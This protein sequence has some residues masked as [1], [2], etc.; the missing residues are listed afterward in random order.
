MVDRIITSWGAY[1]L[2]GLHPLNYASSEFTCIKLMCRTHRRRSWIL[3]RVHAKPSS[4]TRTSVWHTW[5]CMGPCCSTWSFNTCN[6]SFALLW[7]TV[8]QVTFWN[9][10]LVPPWWCHRKGLFWDGVCILRCSVL[11]LPENSVVPLNS[12][13]GGFYVEAC[14]F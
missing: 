10:F 11:C 4:S 1:Y 14:T 5:N 12:F 6:R 7:A 9:S 13:E 8:S 2:Y 3:R